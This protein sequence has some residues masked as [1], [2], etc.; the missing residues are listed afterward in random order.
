MGFLTDRVS[1]RR[2]PRIFL[3]SQNR[4]FR[5]DPA[6][7]ASN[8][9]AKAIVSLAKGCS[10]KKAILIPLFLTLVM[11]V[12]AVAQETRK[13]GDATGPAASR[14][15]VT[16]SGRVSEDATAFVS[17]QDDV[18]EV[19]NAK[20]LIGHQGQQ[21]VV[22]CQLYPDK[23][24]MRVLSVSTAQGEVKYVVNRGDSAFRR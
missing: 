22:K 21:V 17:D 24:E 19:S 15:A 6:S 12:A 5:F 13:S 23:N 16:L 20:V 14:K 10:M 7:A 4:N 18:W 8:N 11:C 9:S 1:G 2:P 3:H